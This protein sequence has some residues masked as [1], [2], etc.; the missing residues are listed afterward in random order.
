MSL[1]VIFDMDGV[2]VNNGEY[3]YKA[4]KKFCANHSIKFSREKFTKVFFGRTNNQVIPDL[5]GKNLAVD[6]IEK[7]ASEKENIYRHMYAPHIRPVNGLVELLLQLQKN[8]IPVAVAT[9]A[10]MANADFVLE[11]LNIKKLISV[12]VDE[13]MVA[14]GKPNPEIYLKTAQLLQTPVSDCVV[15]EDSISGTQAAFDAGAKVIALTTTLNAAQHK[16]AHVIINDFTSVFINNK[17]LN[18][19]E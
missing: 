16:Y 14:N 6:E 13:S 18:I 12:I 15:F 19:K 17:T 3:H 10:P 8:K 5:F 4:W 9:S 2:M 1:A 7:L 11:R